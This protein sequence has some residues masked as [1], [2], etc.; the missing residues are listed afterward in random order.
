[1]LTSSQAYSIVSSFLDSNGW[2][3]VNAL[4]DVDEKHMVYSYPPWNVSSDA[5]GTDAQRLI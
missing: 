3:S 1:M 4:E 2:T 5:N